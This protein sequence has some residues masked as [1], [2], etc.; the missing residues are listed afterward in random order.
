MDEVMICCHLK[1][2]GC[3]IGEGDCDTDDECT[4][5]L[6]CGQK[7]CNWYNDKYWGIELENNVA[8]WMIPD[9]CE[10]G[11]NIYLILF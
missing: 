7:N 8:N 1:P 3:S 11:L 6:R 2:G 4:G 5:E 10:S 9:C